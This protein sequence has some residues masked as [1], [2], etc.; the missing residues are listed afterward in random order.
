MKEARY[1]L[2]TSIWIDLFEKRDE[3]NLP[4]GTWAQNLFDKIIKTNAT[5][6]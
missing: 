5:H 2:D 3:P 1:Y 6:D 4:K